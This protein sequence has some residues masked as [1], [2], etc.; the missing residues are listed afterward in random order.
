MREHAG[1]LERPDLLG[2]PVQHVPIGIRDLIDHAVHVEALAGLQAKVFTPI[3]VERAVA[4]A[5]DLARGHNWLQGGKLVRLGNDLVDDF[6]D[7]R[8]QRL[9]GNARI[10][11]PFGSRPTE[12]PAP[13][14][15]LTLAFSAIRI[16]PVVV[17]TIRTS[18]I[19]SARE[20]DPPKPPNLPDTRSIENCVIEPVRMSCTPSNCP[21]RAAVSLV[22]APLAPRSCSAR[23]ASICAR[24]MT[25]NF[26]ERKSWV[27]SSSAAAA[28]R[29]SP[30]YN[31]VL[32]FSKFMTATRTSSED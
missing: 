32:L 1:H 23:I 31:Q 29:L 6:F 17:F 18:S 8:T 25:L 10:E 22:T 24:S 19:V 21:S 20:Y 7:G 5:D 2:D 28:P 11:V 9:L 12:E 26:P 14:T 30:Q 3:D 16:S 4:G 15:L 13:E 27:V